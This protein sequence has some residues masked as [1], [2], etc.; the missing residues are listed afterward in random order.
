MFYKTMEVYVIPLPTAFFLHVQIDLLS[1]NIFNLYSI[2]QFLAYVP[3]LYPLKA[4]ENQ[5][6]SSV[7][8]RFNMGVL[9]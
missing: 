3:I 5:R 9:A 7:F 6:F 1:L 4:P 8:R 2:N